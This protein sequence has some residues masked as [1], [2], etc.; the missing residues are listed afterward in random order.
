MYKVLYIGYTGEQLSEYFSKHYDIKNR[1][2]NS[3]LAKHFHECRSI[4]NN[5]TAKYQNCHQYKWICK[6]KT[7]TTHGLNTE[8]G[9]YAKEMYNF[10]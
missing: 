10:N 9:D 1:P 8:T 5:H 4:N 6:R 2:D 3:G 7:L